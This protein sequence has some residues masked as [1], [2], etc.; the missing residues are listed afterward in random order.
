MQYV[1]DRHYGTAEQQAKFRM[2][3]LRLR[4]DTLH[5]SDSVAGTATD[6]EKCAVIDK[7]IRRF[8]LIECS[9]NE[10]LTVGRA[11]DVIRELEER[12]ISLHPD[13]R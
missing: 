2:L 13:R 7:T 8:E 5:R 3:A 4:R 10:E 1:D 12:K 9:I 6:C 11:K